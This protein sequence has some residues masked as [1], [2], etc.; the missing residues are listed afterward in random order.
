MAAKSYRRTDAA[1]I[2]VTQVAIA[3]R[4]GVPHHALA[5]LKVRRPNSAT[6]SGA[7][8]AKFC[9]DLKTAAANRGTC[10]SACV[11]G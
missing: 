7:P 5:A 8:N 4:L 3:D 6:T 1:R 11:S 2:R 9:T 10:G